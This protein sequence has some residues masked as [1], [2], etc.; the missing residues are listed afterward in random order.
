MV[1]FLAQ[2]DVPGRRESRP[3]ALGCREG[4]ILALAA[5]GMLIAVPRRANAQDFH[6]II[7][8]GAGSEVER[9][10]RAVSLTGIATSQQWT[11]RPFGP[12]ELA[13][14][15]IGAVQPWSREVTNQG[16]RQTGL[17]IL[18]PEATTIV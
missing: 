4:V 10:L 18:S 2:V 6:I 12:N 3:R 11:I 7:P 15:R 5:I 13:A 1:S 14:M 8:V 17:T 16:L 9:Y